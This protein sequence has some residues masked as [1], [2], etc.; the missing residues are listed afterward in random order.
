MNAVLLLAFGGP[1]H[2][3]EIRPF[4]ANVIRGRHVPP[5]RAEE[6][7]RHYEIVGGCSPLTEVTF[8]QAEALRQHLARE[9]PALP[10]YVG[11]R[12]WKPYV[13]DTLREMTARGVRRAT[14]IVLAPH[15]S[16]ASWEHYIAAVDSG[17]TKIGP[18]APAIDYAGRWH[19]HPLFI[20]AVAS[21]VDA[22]CAA[23]RD[24]WPGPLH[25]LF[26]AHSIPVPM[27]DASGYG[28]QVEETA[29]LISER[30]GLS[31]WSV[32]YQSRS[33]NPRDPWLGPDIR[34]TLRALA[35]DGTAS[36]IVAP[37]GFVCEQ[38]ELTYDL[39]VETRALASELALNF[40]RARAVDDHP[41]FIRLLAEL[42]C[43]APPGD[44]C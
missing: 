2:P 26:T 18:T 38:V 44:A 25:V 12:N 16:E 36:V 39:D 41:A 33:G 7:A 9:G 40:A 5:E 27:S 29:R 32:A 14:A 30:L 24:S 21:R 31:R 35:A 20:E 3:E 28:G 42:V 19:A 10:V 37:I 15:R 43:G 8:R 17:R 23:V 22:R 4:I 6:V 34:D 13:V 11:M 1:T